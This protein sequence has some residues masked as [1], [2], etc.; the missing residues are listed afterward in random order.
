VIKL[1][2]LFGTGDTYLVCSLFHAFETKYGPAT[3]VCKSAHEAIP[4]MFE[5]PYEL[6]DATVALAEANQWDATDN[7]VYVHPSCPLN[8]TRPDQFFFK[9]GS[10]S[11]ADMY[12][13]LLDLPLDTPLERPK[14]YKTQQ[15]DDKVFIIHEA[16]SW[17]NTQPVFWRKLN[18][19]L[20]EA[21][22]I[23]DW[24]TSGTL[25]EL[26]WHCAKAGWVIGPQCGVM[27]ILCH[28]Q[29]PCR[30]SFCTP[31]VEQSRPVSFPV[32][33][34]FPYAYVKN[35]T[36]EDYD[37]DE[38][39]VGDHN[40][41][42]LIA[43]LFSP[44]ANVSRMTAPLSTVN[45]PL[46][47]GDFLDRLAVLTVKMEKF[48][49]E[50][51]HSIRREHDRLWSIYKNDPFCGTYLDALINLHRE[52][53]DVCAKHVPI[54]MTGQEDEAGSVVLA[55]FN[56]RRVELKQQIDRLRNSAYSEVKDYYR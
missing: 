18:N 24:N 31:S 50:H 21:G 16:K 41:D 23:V 3:I 32:K 53:F 47:P 38:Y 36:G 37:V 46:A 40:H 55:Q 34:T 48:T 29:F 11:Q 20:K 2:T 28:A 5:L 43:K 14:L 30:K 9:C 15:I 22:Y 27:G 25:A 54:C 6:D 51:K 33:H 13:A 7:R 26:F 39:E 17:P 52:T 44:G 12:R 4:K 1:V 10:I 49:P 45:T 42:V 8:Y 35:F 56:K 19:A